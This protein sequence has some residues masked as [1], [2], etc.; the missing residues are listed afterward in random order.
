[1]RSRVYD[2]PKYA[3]TE[4]RIKMNVAACRRRSQLP[5]EMIHIILQSEQA[6]T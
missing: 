5:C 1:M 6:M 4:Q 3:Y 2:M